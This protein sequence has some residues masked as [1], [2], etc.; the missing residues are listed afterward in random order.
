MIRAR[1]LPRPSRSRAVSAAPVVCL[2]VARARNGVI[3]KDGKV[4]WHLPGDLPRFKR[5]TMGKPIIM[6]RVT[7]ERDIGRPLP[8]RLNIVLTRDTAFAAGGAAVAASLDDALAL[9]RVE[10]ART[11]A[12]E[13]HVIGGAQI[14]RL[15]REAAGRVYL[16]EVLADIDGDTVMPGFP[17]AV[18]RTVSRE[19]FPATDKAPAHAFIVLEKR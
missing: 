5:L 19:D 11:G 6:G 12:D 3:G 1:P 2:T 13:I 7:F 18:W 14:Y 4:P 10:A 17:E 8:G 15:A 9:A 16:T